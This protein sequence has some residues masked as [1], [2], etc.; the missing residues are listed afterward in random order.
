MH[1]DITLSYGDKTLIID[2]KY[3]SRVTVTHNENEK[4]NSANLYQIFS[5]VK[6]CEAQGEVSGLLLYAKPSAENSADYSY[7]MS[8]NK[9]SV[10]T[11][12]LNVP[13]KEISAQLNG[14]ATEKFGIEPQRQFWV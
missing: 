11:L 10:K 8:G 1:T 6:N 7:S 3:Y 13:F 4:F 9:I 12:D 2:T 5:Y 14:I